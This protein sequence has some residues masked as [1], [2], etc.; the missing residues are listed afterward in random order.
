MGNLGLQS[1]NNA[2]TL[3]RNEARSNWQES[4]KFVSTSIKISLHDY[5]HKESVTCNALLPHDIILLTVEYI[6]FIMCSDI[7]RGD[8]Q[9]I[10]YRFLVE[11]HTN[12]DLHPYS[13]LNLLDRTSIPYFHLLYRA[14]L[15]TPPGPKGIIN[16]IDSYALL[17]RCFERENLVMVFHTEFDHVF[18]LFI[19]MKLRMTRIGPRQ[20]LADELG[21]FLIRSQF[22]YGDAKQNRDLAD[23]M[24]PRIV[25]T[26]NLNGGIH[27][28]N[29][30]LKGIVSKKLPN[31]WFMTATVHIGVKEDGKQI[32]YLFPAYHPPMNSIGNELC[33]GTQY[34]ASSA[35]HYFRLKDVE[36]FQI[37]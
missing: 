23:K 35:H 37:L 32:H 34:I 15:H 3:D 26:L 16:E 21:L 33:G 29:A 11:H 8:E 1:S 28:K 6:G 31:T 14:S 4:P 2:S 7:L 17:S 36:L 30:L 18:T 9:N 19:R 13:C 24:C 12:H 5:I 20:Q 10:F 22:V 25:T 27:E